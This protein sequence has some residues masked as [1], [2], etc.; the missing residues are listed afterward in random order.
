MNQAP[1][2][3]SLLQRIFLK[4]KWLW[5]VKSGKASGPSIKPTIAQYLTERPEVNAAKPKYQAEMSARKTI[6]KTTN[7]PFRI[8]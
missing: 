4:A 1:T 5:V 6:S 7:S 2:I 3:H 8:K